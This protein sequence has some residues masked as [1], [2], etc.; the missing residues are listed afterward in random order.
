MNLNKYAINH[1]LRS[2][3]NI[4]TRSDPHV[5]GGSKKISHINQYVRPSC[6]TKLPTLVT[7]GRLQDL[8]VAIGKFPGVDRA[9]DGPKTAVHHHRE[10]DPRP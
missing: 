4:H 3:L 6:P 2:F 5:C 7:D 8:S 9:Q 10:N 1:R